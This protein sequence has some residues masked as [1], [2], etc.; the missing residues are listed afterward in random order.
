MIK[1]KDILNEIDWEGEYSD[2]KKSCMPLEVVKDM[3]NAQLAWYSL[4]DKEKKKHPEMDVRKRN[5][6]IPVI[7]KGNIPKTGEGD[8][9]VDHF[10]KQ[11]TGRPEKVFDKNPKMERSDKGGYQYTV[12]TG[13]PALR[14]IV[15][16]EKENKFYVINTCP[17]AGSCIV[18]C[19]ARKGH[20]I[21]NDGKNLKYIQ[22]LNMLLNDPKEYE[23]LILDEL[24]PEAYKISRQS[25][26]EGKDIK[27]VIRWNDAG[28]FFSQRYFDVALN[29]TK[30]L[31]KQGYNIESYAYTKV[32]KVANIADPDF[33]MT[34]ST[35]A[36]KREKGQV[37]VTTTKSSPIVPKAVFAKFFTPKGSHWVTG[38]DGK[39]IFKTDKAK[40]ELR[41]S[42][43]S[44]YH[45]EFGIPYDSLVYTDELPAKQGEKFQ[46]NVI[47]LPQGD[48]DVGAQRKDVKV[49]F[50][51]QH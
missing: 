42:I 22:R 17:G 40:E 47:V 3:L 4:S 38:E 39:P 28:D 30:K 23:E 45:K 46:Y 24:D 2:V 25:R 32:G 43:W 14:S 31:K 37:D 50:N 18:D 13:I 19:F 49:T 27:L 20:Y 5:V 21:M 34:F 36:T 26:K 16:S 48:S 29:V 33:L 51:L 15:Y 1:L 44:K 7:S 9:D 11:I 8:I 10:I 12:N 6:S 41:A 35:D